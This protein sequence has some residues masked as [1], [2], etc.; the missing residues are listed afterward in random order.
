[1]MD[2][3]WDAETPEN[4]YKCYADDMLRRVNCV[5]VKSESK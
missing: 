1:M 3:K 2:I 5:K 4:K